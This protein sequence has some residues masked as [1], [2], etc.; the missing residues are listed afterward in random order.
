MCKE[1]SQKEYNIK[2]K[3][4]SQG[5]NKIILRAKIVVLPSNL[6]K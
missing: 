4:T 2:K 6:A 1:N 3:P 5:I